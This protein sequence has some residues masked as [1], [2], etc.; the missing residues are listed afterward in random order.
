MIEELRLLIDLQ[1]NLERQHFIKEEIENPSILKELK[2]PYEEMK[3]EKEEREKNIRELEIK[4]ENLEKEINEKKEDIKNLRQKLQVVRNQKEYSEV[5]N[6]IDNIQKTI[7]SKEE[8][9][10]QI[11]E[12]LENEKKLVEEKNLKFKPLE[13]EYLEA[14]KKWEEIKKKYEEELNNLDLEE[15]IIKSKL[16]KET[17]YLFEKIYKLR[18][19]QAVVPVQNGSCSGCYI[20]LRPQQL[21]DVKSGNQIIQCDQCSRILYIE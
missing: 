6:G 11:M 14:I 15:K 17:L 4:Q 2:S 21:A 19:G 7:S 12:N 13:E 10:L 3:K 16:S 9:I 18:K 1:K 5:L 8:E 20:L